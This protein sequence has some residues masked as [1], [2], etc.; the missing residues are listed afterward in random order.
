MKVII[1]LLTALALAVP[2]SPIS[3]V[4]AD[5]LL[6]KVNTNALSIDK[7][8]NSLDIHNTTHILPINFEDVVVVPPN[9]DEIA[10]SESV[11]TTLTRLD[12]NSEVAVNVE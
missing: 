10:R 8:G 12:S 4:T 2:I 3:L 11:E 5:E 6:V 9:L 1:K 7:A